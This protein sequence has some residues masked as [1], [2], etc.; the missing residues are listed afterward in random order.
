MKIIPFPYLDTRIKG[1]EDT[2]FWKTI[3]KSMKSLIPSGVPS[4][5]VWLRACRTFDQLDGVSIL[6][7]QYVSLNICKW[8]HVDDTVQILD[9]IYIIGLN[10]LWYMKKC[11][12]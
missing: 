6:T 11:K 4:E 1:K 3:N 12:L 7:I 9:Y 8:L 5:D 10:M 2:L